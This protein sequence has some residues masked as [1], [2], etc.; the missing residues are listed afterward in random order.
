MSCR[1]SKH[2]CGFP[3]VLSGVLACVWVAGARAAGQRGRPIEFSAPGGEAATTVNQFSPKQLQDEILQRK[4]EEA[5]PGSLDIFGNGNSLGGVATEAPR[6]PVSPPVQNKRVKEL[7]DRH[8]NRAFLTPDDLKSE[9]TLEEMFKLQ[10]HDRNGQEEQDQSSVEQYYDSLDRKQAGST[11]R[12]ADRFADRPDNRRDDNFASVNDSARPDDL[13]LQTESKVKD[14]LN[15]DT[16]PATWS[17]GSGGIFSSLFG[18]ARAL[19]VER[20][21]AQKARMEEFKQLL[22]PR[23]PLTPPTAFAKPMNPQFGLASPALLPGVSPDLT[24]EPLFGGGNAGVGGLPGGPSG[25]N[26]LSSGPSSFAPVAPVQVAPP[27]LTIP[28]RKF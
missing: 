22:E 5:R 12:L 27:A 19:P 8:K 17:G 3:L 15:S 24:T 4:L 10:K 14:L 2:G 16:T 13:P 11:N 1:F 18:S 23:F 9:P 28:R 26:A 7:L 25:L 6:L 20:T 21:L